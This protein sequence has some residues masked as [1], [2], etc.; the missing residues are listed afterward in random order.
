MPENQFERYEI[1]KNLRPPKIKMTLY[2]NKNE[3]IGRI[4]DFYDVSNKITLGNTNELSFSIPFKIEKKKQND[5][6]YNV[7][8]FK[9]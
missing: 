8:Y 7:G 5:K 6:K 4:K 9:I 3:T 1:D 2:K